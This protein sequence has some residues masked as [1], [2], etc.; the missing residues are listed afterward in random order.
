MNRYEYAKALRKPLGHIGEF[1]A[2]YAR[3][4]KGD[5]TGVIIADASRRLA[6]TF[7]EVGSVP[8]VYPV[9]QG[10]DIRSLNNP[11]LEGF[12]VRLAFPNYAPDRVHIMGLD[13]GE[14]LSA[15]GGYTP[16]EQMNAAQAVP[17]TANIADFRLSVVSG[18]T[19]QVNPGKYYQNSTGDW[20]YFGGDT[21][22]LTMPTTSGYHQM[23]V[24]YLDTET[25][26][27]DVLSNTAE[28]GS[29]KDAF[30]YATID[31]L[32]IPDGALLSGAVHCVQGVTDLAETDIYRNA[33]PRVIFQAR[34]TT[35]H[36]STAN[37]S[38]P[39]T[40]AEL[41]AAL[42]TPAAV[43][44]GYAALIN[45]GDAGTNEYMVWSDGTNW[46][47]VEGTKAT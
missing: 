30:G 17:Q 34:R 18:L 11:T 46:F 32:T 36:Y 22:A 24:I 35:V 44:A 3:L 23:Q 25:G 31:A 28:L 10:I 2:G 12:R 8:S 14:G 39:P 5:G 47:Y 16:Q 9:D 41:D 29:N 26:D 27:L 1:P 43:G 33:D 19:V 6:W 45:D 4:G 40:D 20:Q 7:Q 38:N 42:G 37:V 13:D 15:V 21:L